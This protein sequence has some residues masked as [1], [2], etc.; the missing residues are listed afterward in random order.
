MKE[1]NTELKLVKM[2]VD[3]MKPYANNPRRN[4]DAVEGVE[5]SIKAFGYK[6]PIVVDGDGVI[7]T[8][9]T[10]YKA[11]KELGLKS[12][13]VVMADDL[14]PKQVKAFRLAD[15]KTAEAAAWDFEKLDMELDK[16]QDIDMDD[17]GF[18]L[19]DEEMTEEFSN[20]ELDIDDYSDEQFDHECPKC[21][22]KF[23]D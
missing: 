8:G 22:F 21:G 17:F 20:A 1:I 7:V 4:D 19:T 9:H 5:N 14:T 6:V 13:T 2:K 15:N 23:N 12:L 11:A 10:R 3:D 18:D 16:I